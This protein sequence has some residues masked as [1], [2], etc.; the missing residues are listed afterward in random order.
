MNEQSTPQAPSKRRRI[1]KIVGAIAALTVAFALGQS[2]TPAAQETAQVAA[3]PT[4]ITETA[5]PQVIT[6]TVTETVEV[7]K[8]P[9]ECLA[10]L[11]DADAN[12]ALSAEFA[13]ITA[14]V[15][16]ISGEAVMAAF[17]WDVPAIERLTADLEGTTARM[18]TVNARLSMSSYATNRDACRDA[19]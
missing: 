9:A 5:E 15:M 16:T 11:D 7:V 12:L 18:E 3:E 14:E 4:V 2:S 17:E 6:E 19:S 1:L 10:A 8:I 13:E